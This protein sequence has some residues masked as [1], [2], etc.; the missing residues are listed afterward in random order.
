MTSWPPRKEDG[1]Q[2]LPQPWKE[3]RLRG[4]RTAEGYRHEHDE[5]G[6]FMAYCTLSGAC[7]GYRL[8]KDKPHPMSTR[9]VGSRVLLHA[10]DVPR[11]VLLTWVEG[12]RGTWA[13][14][15]VAGQSPTHTY[16]SVPVTGRQYKQS[17]GPL[18]Y[19]TP[20]FG[21]AG[22]RYPRQWRQRAVERQLRAASCEPSDSADPLVRPLGGGGLGR[23]QQSPTG[24]DPDGLL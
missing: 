14:L 11:S 6:A 12:C 24:N 4:G 17:R 5:I 9:Y 19:R 18:Q 2:G 21:T 8:G 1:T 10:P 22:T 15:A 3:S 13:G 16:C 23:V 20:G 7:R